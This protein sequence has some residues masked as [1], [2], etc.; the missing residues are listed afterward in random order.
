MLELHG[1]CDQST[2]F[3][4]EATNFPE[5]KTPKK[6]RP[7]QL[8]SYTCQ[9]LKLQVISRKLLRFAQMVL[10]FL[11]QRL[12]KSSDSTKAGGKWN[13]VILREKLVYLRYRPVPGGSS[14]F[15]PMFGAKGGRY[16]MSRT[17]RTLADF[18]FW[19]NSVMLS[20]LKMSFVLFA[21]VISAQW[22]G[23]NKNWIWTHR[24]INYEWFLPLFLAV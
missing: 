20:V 4:L 12:E 21:T 24:T 10:Q 19:V 9:P 11:H 3:W 5:A 2:F 8:K 18:F 14:R 17:A 7:R 22:S 1:I 13:P 6:Q 16:S 15:G 23:I